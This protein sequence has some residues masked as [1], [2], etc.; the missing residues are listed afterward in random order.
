MDRDGTVVAERT[1]PTHHGTA[2][3]V[4]AQ[5][6]ALVEWLVPGDATLTALGVS[7]AAA[8]DPRNGRLNSIAN[9]HG[10]ENVALA[11]ELGRHVA[12]RGW[13]GVVAVAN[14]AELGAVAEGRLGAAV[15]LRDYVSITIGTGVGMGMV[16]GGSVLRGWRGMA[17]ELAYLPVAGPG[18]PR[19]PAGDYEGLVGGRTLQVRCVA[20]LAAARQAGE[21][22]RL[23]P[24]TSIATA[25]ELARAGDPVAARLVEHECQDI[26]IGIATVCAII[27]PQLVVLSGGIGSQPGLVA[28]VRRA[29]AALMDEAPPIEISALGER[30]QLLGALEIARDAAKPPGSASAGSV[31]GRG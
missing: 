6:M 25:L 8:L 27:D 19:D 13:T 28:P 7:V 12:A 3:E 23:D 26:A 10:L 5:V 18:V 17:G 20:E 2:D 22:T 4:L 11:D 24:R 9:I 1:R 15:G 29:V 31:P 16:M 30:A 14:D 21:S